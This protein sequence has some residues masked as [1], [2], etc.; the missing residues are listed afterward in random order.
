M[1]SFTEMLGKL[2]QS[3]VAYLFKHTNLFVKI[4]NFRFG[5]VDFY[6]N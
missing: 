6:N 1:T 5:R 4:N 2:V 3:H